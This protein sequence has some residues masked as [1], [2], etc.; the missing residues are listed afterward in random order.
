MNEWEWHYLFTA[1]CLSERKNTHFSDHF[2]TSM[3]IVSL[4]ASVCLRS[5][6]TMVAMVFKKSFFFVTEPKIAPNV[7]VCV[8]QWC[9][10]NCLSWWANDLWWA[11]KVVKAAGTNVEIYCILPF[12]AQSA[13]IAKMQSIF[14]LTIK[15]RINNRTFLENNIPPNGYNISG[16]V[17]ATN[18]VNCKRPTHLSSTEGIDWYAV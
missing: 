10:N 18:G 5:K 12:T 17:Y 2:T 4:S 6:S 9:V 11:L 16:C 1:P 3:L 13:L 15:L 8:C 14:T 7:C